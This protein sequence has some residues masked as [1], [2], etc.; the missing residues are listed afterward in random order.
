MKRLRNTLQPK[1]ERWTDP[2]DYP[3]GAGG[4]P[5]PSHDYVEAIEGEIIVELEQEDTL[6]EVT[7]VLGDVMRLT[8]DQLQRTAIQSWLDEEP[9]G[10]DPEVAGLTVSKWDVGK[11]EGN[12]ITLKVE[13][14]EC[15]L[16]E[17]PEPDYDPME[18]VERRER[19]DAQVW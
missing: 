2:G 4:G 12:R 3:S 14:F 15:E 5:L 7:L 13:E 18:E 1:I 9:Q 6:S 17:P 11:I 19:R 16:P 10:L 8:L